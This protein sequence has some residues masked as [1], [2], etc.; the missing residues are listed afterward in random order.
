MSIR[1]AVTGKPGVGK[2]TLVRRSLDRLDCVVGGM[3]T[4]DV[5]VRGRRVGFELQDLRCGA[6][7]TL[8]SLEGAGPRLGRYHV[9]L[10][11]LEEIG[12]AAIEDA[13]LRA[14]LV[15]IDEV[16]TMELFSSRFVEA[17]ETALGSGKSMLV[18]VQAKSR[19]PL[20]VR[21]RDTFLLVTVK[22]DNRDGLAGDIAEK[23]DS[24][25]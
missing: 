6:L 15:V 5:R 11:D 12:A 23:I 3:L 2:S 25:L 22:R 8:A 16:G 14:D 9:N 17:V 20:A 13:I 24:A 19:H 18:V 1:M 21:I 7:G 10:H 4:R